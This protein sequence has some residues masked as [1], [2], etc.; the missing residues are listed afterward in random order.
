[1][2]SAVNGLLAAFDRASVVALGEKHWGREDAEFRLS[3]IRHPVFAQKVDDIIIEFANPLH[4]DV[5][6]RFIS[7][8]D[9]DSS[10][11]R[12]VWQDTTQPGTWDSPLYEDF[13]VEVRSLN[14]ALPADH[15]LR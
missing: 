6:D 11:L 10:D 15:R 12:K 3:L 4:Q 9:V 8:A 7:G 5:L 2:V 14:L 1:M 13:I